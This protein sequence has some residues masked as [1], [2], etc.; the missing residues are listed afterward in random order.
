[1]SGSPCATKAARARLQRSVGEH[2]AERIKGAGF[3]R[4]CQRSR[5]SCSAQGSSRDVWGQWSQKSNCTSL[6]FEFNV[7]WQLLQIF[8]ALASIRAATLVS[9]QAADVL[10]ALCDLLSTILNSSI[11]SSATTH[12]VLARYFELTSKRR[13]IEVHESMAR[14]YRRLSELRDC[15]KDINKYARSILALKG[16]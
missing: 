7:G 12:P 2:L 10:S 6:C 14:V 9:Q 4:L 13:E 16:S 1:M 5:C 15:E 11:T 8:D 3:F